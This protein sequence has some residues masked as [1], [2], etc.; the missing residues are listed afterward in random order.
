MMMKAN[1]FSSEYGVSGLVF[2]KYGSHGI[3]NVIMD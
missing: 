3:K 2:L 1:L